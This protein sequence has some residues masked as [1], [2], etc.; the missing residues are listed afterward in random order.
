M[1]RRAVAEGTVA[2][3]KGARAVHVEH[4]TPDPTYE[5][6]TLPTV[7]APHEGASCLAQL[8]ALAAA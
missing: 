7:R 6:D 8:A 4:F 5:P 3:V 2:A 1:R